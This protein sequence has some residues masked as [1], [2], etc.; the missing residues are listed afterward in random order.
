MG[1]IAVDVLL[2]RHER[3]VMDPEIIMILKMGTNMK[4]I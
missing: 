1:A 2:E 4:A 3:S